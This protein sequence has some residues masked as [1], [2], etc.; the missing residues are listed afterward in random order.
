[1]SVISQQPYLLRALYEWCLD[2]GNTPYITVRVDNHTRVPRAFV[3][4]GFVV[5]NVGASAVRNIHM[6]NELV[7]FSARF[8]GVSQLI[9]VPVGNVVAIY[10]R[11]T[12]EGMAFDESM[13]SAP[14]AADS[15][16]MSDQDD[17]PQPPKGRPQLTVVK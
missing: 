2:N 7:S 17:A 6:D 13:L 3:K 10:A 4:D 8:G 1:L 11:E 15:D 5:L 9:E 16:Q 12:G 14:E